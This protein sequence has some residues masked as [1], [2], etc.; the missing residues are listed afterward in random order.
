MKLHVARFCVLH[1]EV[2][3]NEVALK[4]MRHLDDI[5]KVP[6]ETMLDFDERVSLWSEIGVGA[7]SWTDKGIRDWVRDVRDDQEDD[8]KRSSWATA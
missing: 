3:H 5:V 2:E 8:L 6:F 1:V 4:V 7:N